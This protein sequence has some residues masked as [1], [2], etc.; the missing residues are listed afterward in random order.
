MYSILKFPDAVCT[1]ARNNA[2][3]I[4]RPKNVYQHYHAHVYFGPGQ[5][6]QARALCSSAAELFDVRMGRVHERPV[7]PH[8][9]WSCQ[10]TFDTDTFDR[11]IPWLEAHRDGLDVFVHGQTGDDLADHTTHATWLGQEHVLKLD[12]FR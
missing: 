8:P 3:M 6:E 1:A 7:G 12:M 5:V 9:E 11:V 4:K 2:V 10:L